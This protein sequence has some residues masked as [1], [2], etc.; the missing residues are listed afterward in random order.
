MGM[1]VSYSLDTAMPEKETICPGTKDQRQTAG[2]TG[3]VQR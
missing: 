2:S 3:N 1:Q